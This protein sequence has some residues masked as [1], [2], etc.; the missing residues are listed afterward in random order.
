M[1]LHM[2]V[3][4]LLTLVGSFFFTVD[5]PVYGADVFEVKGIYVD[6]TAKSVTEARKKAMREG[7]GRA[8]AILLKRLT[9]KDDR[10]LLP[11]IEPRHRAQ[12][13]RDFSVTGEKSSSVRYLATYSYHFKPDAIRNLLKARGIAFAETISKPVL[14]LPL[15]ENGQQAT[16]WNDPNPWREAWSGLGVQH[17]LV[18]IALPLGDLADI[19]G[20]SIQQ[21]AGADEA[22]MMDMANRYGVN[23]AVVAHMVVTG[24]DQAGQPNNVDLVINRVGSKYAGRMTLLGVAAQEGETSQAFLKRAA[25]EVADVIEE[26]WKRDNLLQFGMVDVLPVNLNIRNL[27]EWLSVQERLKKVPVVRRVE[28]ALLSRDAVQLNLHFI[29]K[30]DQL[31]SSLRQVDLDLAVTGESWS[32]V[33]LS[34]RG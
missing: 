9:M 28:L 16:L 33:N 7:E 32:L 11:W 24:R 1:T 34:G 19:S 21:A 12:Y 8:F 25:M 17:G 15:F 23:S 5:S 10:G 18:P 26:S 20:V 13:I 22:A 4:A 30:L 31:I 2:R 27:K 6:V 3:V 29:G 14:V